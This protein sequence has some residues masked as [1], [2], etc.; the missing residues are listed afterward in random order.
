MRSHFK[1]VTVILSAYHTG[2]PEVA[3]GGGPNF[4]KRHGIIQKIKSHGVKV[5]EVH[6]PQVHEQFDGEIAR[7][8][9]IMRR[10][11]TLV[12]QAQEQNS[13]PVILAGNCRS[14]VGVLS[15]ISQ[16][17]GKIGG[18]SACIWFDA[19]DDFNTPDTLTSGYFD[20]M[21]IAMMGNLCFKSMLSTIPDFEPLDL[22][23]LIHIGMRDVNKL[24]LDHVREAGLAVA[25]GDEDSEVDFYSGMESWLADRYLQSQPAMIHLDVDSLDTSIGKANR[26][27]APGGLTELDLVKCLQ[28][29][30]T[31][32]QPLSLTVA[33]FDPNFEGA[34]NI[35]KVTIQAVSASSRP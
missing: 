6:L 31:T 30:A 5:S 14:A 33:S 34:E 3:V 21:P 11:S 1:S 20:S 2:I 19:H 32:L 24:E 23:R 22:S 13:F 25:G 28:R 27:A 8:F 26:F 12:R 9:E 35:A 29:T 4:L 10:T 7:S 15:G 16:A 18:K 17:V